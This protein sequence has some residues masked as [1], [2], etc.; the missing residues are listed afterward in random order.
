MGTRRH[1]GAKGEGEGEGEGE[2]RKRGYAG[3][4]GKMGLEIGGML[5]WLG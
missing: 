2:R 1:E 4:R 5:I 3:V